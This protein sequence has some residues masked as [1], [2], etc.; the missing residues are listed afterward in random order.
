MWGGHMVKMIYKSKQRQIIQ[1]EVDEVDEEL[2][3]AATTGMYFNP[4]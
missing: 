3:C 2:N 4:F 1:N